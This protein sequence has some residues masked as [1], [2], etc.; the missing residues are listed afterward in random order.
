M[1][2]DS[3]TLYR[4]LIENNTDEAINKSNSSLNISLE[5][6]FSKSEVKKIPQIFHIDDPPTVLNEITSD[7]KKQI[8]DKDLIKDMIIPNQLDFF[9]CEESIKKKSFYSSEI[10]YRQKTI[11]SR[12]A[13]TNND[14]IENKIDYNNDEFNCI[15]AEEEISKNNSKYIKPYNVIFSYNPQTENNSKKSINGFA[16]IFYRKYYKNRNLGD[17]IVSYY[18]PIIFCIISEF[19]FYNSFYLLCNQIKNLYKEKNIEV[20][21]EILIYNI[22]NYSISPI[23]NDIFLFIEPIK[24]PTKK[25]ELQILKENNKKKVNFHNNFL[26]NNKDDNQIAEAEIF[27]EIEEEGKK[28]NNINNNDVKQLK[29]SKIKTIKNLNKISQP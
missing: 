12:I 21:L 1:G 10:N 14:Y 11:L 23:N 5:E 13:T 26:Y 4:N 8:P 17:R 19:P 2:F 6:L 29:T 16:H 27:E 28:E 22:I 3:K 7:Y 20:P 9:L 24:F 18:V 15:F 25:I